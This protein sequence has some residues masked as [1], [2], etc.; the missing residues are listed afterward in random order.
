M[1]YSSEAVIESMLCIQK[2]PD[3][4]IFIRIGDTIV[5]VGYAF[6]GYNHSEY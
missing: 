5:I 4:G 6:R 3:V 2:N 1:N